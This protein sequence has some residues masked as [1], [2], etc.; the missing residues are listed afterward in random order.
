MWL[1]EVSTSEES[2]LSDE[3]VT[4]IIKFVAADSASVGYFNGK[5]EILNLE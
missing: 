1:D 3:K 5:E 2:V 4:L